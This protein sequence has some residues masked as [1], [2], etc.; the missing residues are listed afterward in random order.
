[1]TITVIEAF[2][3]EVVGVMISRRIQI[4][5]WPDSV[6]ETLVGEDLAN[7]TIR[8]ASAVTTRC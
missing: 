4:H 6:I 1:M 3:R 7:L 2:T 5:S 8:V